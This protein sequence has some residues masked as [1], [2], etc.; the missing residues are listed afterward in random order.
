LEAT[1]ITPEQRTQEEK[2]KST[3][4]I[5]EARPT[6][7]HP[8]TSISKAQSNEVINMS[9]RIPLDRDVRASTSIKS[10]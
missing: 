10:Y 6:T 7:S 4:K 2:M 3:T 5:T 8:S 9:I 1:K